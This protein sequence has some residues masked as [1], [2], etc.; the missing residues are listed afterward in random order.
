MISRV[1]AILA[2]CMLVWAAPTPASA[3]PQSQTYPTKPVT[4]VVG[5][6]PGGGVDFIARTLSKHMAADLGQTLV[7]DNKAGAAG[8]IGASAIA[9]AAPDG[10]TIG[11]IGNGELV[12]NSLLYKKLIYNPDGDLTAIGP[13]AKVPFLFAVNASLPVRNVQE[14]VA[15]ARQKPLQ[16]ASGGIGH[17]NHLAMEMF[18][19]R[20][21]FQIEGVP[22]KGMAPALQDFLSGQIPAMFIDLATATAQMASGRFRVL[23]VS[24]KERLPA[25]PEVPTMREAGVADYD[26]YA[27]QGLV[28]P[29]GTPKAVVSRISMALGKALKNP[30]VEKAFRDAGMQPIPGNDADLGA[31]VAA[32]KKYWTALLQSLNIKLD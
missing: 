4:W 30:E 19:S 25:L 21:G 29:V 14:F 32:D 20:A 11:S 23:A 22:Y 3:Q 28:A 12:F 31:L 13:V 24:T 1:M 26:V 10:Y 27:W 5:Y 7:V 16:Y 9:R 17:P 18:K 15:Y 6:P 8:S 2:T